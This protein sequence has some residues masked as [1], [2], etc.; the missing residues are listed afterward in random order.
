MDVFNIFYLRNLTAK[1]IY[2]FRNS[3]KIYSYEKSELNYDQ[4]GSL[5]KGI[6][7]VWLGNDEQTEK[8]IERDE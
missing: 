1:F 2:T 3:Q 5:R 8:G 6:N 7:S 4:T